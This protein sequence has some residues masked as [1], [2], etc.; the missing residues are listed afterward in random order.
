MD[1]TG[2]AQRAANTYKYL[3]IVVPLP[4]LWLLGSIA[5]AAMLGDLRGSISAYYG[6]PLRDVFVGALMASG[7]CMI[8]YKGRSKLEDYALNF[9]GVNAFFVGLVANSFHDVLTKTRAEEAKGRVPLVG[10]EDLK[11][12]LGVAVAGFALVLAVGLFLDRRLM[13]WMTFSWGEQTRAANGLI[14]F[15]FAGEAVVLAM[16][17]WLLLGKEDLGAFST[18]SALHFTAAAL[19]VINLGF[20]AASYALPGKLRTPDEIG[21]M[22]ASPR[23]GAWQVFFAAVPLVMAVVLVVGGIAIWQKTPR[24]ILHTE[25]IEIALFVIFWVGA[26]WREWTPAEVDPEV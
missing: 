9:A 12:Y 15:S 14:V 3:R 20:A 25:W 6:S 1:P 26:T 5:V 10:S 13:P 7:I 18:Y 4:A 22:V 11:L 17:V 23:A 2:D 21:Q 8:A 16:V 24:A 19:L